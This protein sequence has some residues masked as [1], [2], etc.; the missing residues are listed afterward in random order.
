MTKFAELSAFA[1]G[2]RSREEKIAARYRAVGATSPD[3][4]TDIVPLGE[5]Q[6]RSFDHLRAQGAIL[7]ARGGFY[8][9]ETAFERLRAGRKNLF[10]TSAGV[11]LALSAVAGW[12]LKR[13]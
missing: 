6:G 1:S 5:K 11:G 12:L 7:G 13:R 3:K 9:D 4:A 8:L 2:K 10:L